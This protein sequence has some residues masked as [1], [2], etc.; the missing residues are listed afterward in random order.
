MEI[1]S[2]GLYHVHIGQWVTYKVGLVTWHQAH[3]SHTIFDKQLQ[4]IFVVLKG[5]IGTVPAVIL[6]W[7]NFRTV[8][9]DLATQQKS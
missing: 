5:S 3:Q 9:L 8:L 2:Q 7:N 4:F 1:T 6:K